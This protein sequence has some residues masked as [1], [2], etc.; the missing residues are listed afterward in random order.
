LAGSV[1]N[2]ERGAKKPFDRQKGK[3][4]KKGRGKKKIYNKILDLRV[5]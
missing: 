1:L 5:T 3:M 4:I 2:E